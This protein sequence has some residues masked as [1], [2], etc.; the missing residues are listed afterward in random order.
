[1][2][3]KDMRCRTADQVSGNRSRKHSKMLAVVHAD[4]VVERGGHDG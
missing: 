4:T 2:R 3:A 1:M